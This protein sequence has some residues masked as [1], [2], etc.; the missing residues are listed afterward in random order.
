MG[1]V[2]SLL[3]WNVPSCRREHRGGIYR[4]LFLLIAEGVIRLCPL[5]LEA[6][7]STEHAGFEVGD[8]WFVIVAGG[9]GRAC[10]RMIHSLHHKIVLL[11]LR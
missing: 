10:E 9:M 11:L 6:T 4:L 7:C 3:L 5:R 2:V 8:L 1:D